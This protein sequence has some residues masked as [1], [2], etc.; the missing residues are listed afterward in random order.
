M[1]HFIKQNVGGAAIKV[2]MIFANSVFLVHSSSKLFKSI[3]LTHL[4]LYSGY[5][6]VSESIFYMSNLVILL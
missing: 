5:I 1:A 3:L 6:N 2:F 4:I